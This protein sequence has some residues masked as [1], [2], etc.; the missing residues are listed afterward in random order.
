MVTGTSELTL[1]PE[2]LA[3]IETRAAGSISFL[4]DP[5]D[6]DT[7]PPLELPGANRT[8]TPPPELFA[9]TRPPAPRTSTLPPLVEARRS[10]LTASIVI[11]PPLVS[12]LRLPRTAVLVMLPP[13]VFA[14]T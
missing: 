12:A 9:S 7:T 1:P 4:T 13:E 11:Q 8:V 3:S 2:A 14:T 10:P 5:P 6:E